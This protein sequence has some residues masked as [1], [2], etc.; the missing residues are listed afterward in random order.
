MGGTQEVRDGNWQSSVPEVGE[1]ADLLVLPCS[2]LPLSPTEGN[3]SVAWVLCL[4]SQSGRRR[5]S[6]S[7]VGFFDASC[8]KMEVVNSGLLIPSGL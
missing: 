7:T 3:P 8:D 5:S 1:L 2:P 4:A 6:A